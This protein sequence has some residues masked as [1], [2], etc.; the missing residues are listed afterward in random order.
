MDMEM[1][2]EITSFIKY[3]GATLMVTYYGQIKT[4]TICTKAGHKAN[5]CPTKGKPIAENQLKTGYTAAM[6]A[7]KT[8]WTLKDKRAVATTLLVY[9]VPQKNKFMELSEDSDEEDTNKTEAETQKKILWQ[10]EKRK[11]NQNK[12]PQI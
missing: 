12:Q 2:K 4:C 1:A 8:E 11:N 9:I 3:K 5:E 10:C 6:A 7:N